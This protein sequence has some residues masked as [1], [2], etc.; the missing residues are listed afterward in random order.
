MHEEFEDIK[1]VIR[2]RTPKNDIH[3]ELKDTK[4]VISG[5]TPKK[6]TQEE[7]EDAKGV[8]RAVQRR[9]IYT[10]GLNIQKE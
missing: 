8:I 10:K 7:F 3:E 4:E 9:R 5:R 2:G 6:D 1:G